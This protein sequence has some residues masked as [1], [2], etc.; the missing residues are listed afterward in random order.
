MSRYLGAL[1]A[2]ALGASHGLS[3]QTVLIRTCPTQPT[4]SGFGAC[5][6]SQW[7]VPSSLAIIDVLRTG[8]TADVWITPSQLVAA[9]RVYACTDPSITAGPFGTGCP[10]FLTG[11]TSN[12][13]D[14]SKVVFGTVPAAAV[15]SIHYH[16]GAPTQNTDNSPLTD[17]AGYKL[18]IRPQSVPTYASF[19]QLPPNATDYLAKNLIGAQ[20][21]E[22]SAYNAPGVDGAMSDEFCSLPQPSGP[23]PGRVTNLTATAN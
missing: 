4:A 12:W 18:Y 8:V 22:I 2:L 7:S 10:S 6:N 9:D 16:W 3:A 17:L 19:I 21:A 14:A 5:T 13:L 23:V 11:Q 20:C 1:C 15:G